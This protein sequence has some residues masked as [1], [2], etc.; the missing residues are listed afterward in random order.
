MPITIQFN[1]M[2][3]PLAELEENYPHIISALEQY[4]PAQ[5]PKRRRPRKKKECVSDLIDKLIET[6]DSIE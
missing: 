4:L 3:I 6:I 2:T 5:K 1:S